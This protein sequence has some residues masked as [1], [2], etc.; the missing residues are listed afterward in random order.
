MTA[1]DHPTTYAGVATLRPM[2]MDVASRVANGLKA[3]LR[4]MFNRRRLFSLNELSDHQLADIGLERA[5]L[6]EAKLTSISVDPTATL[7][8]LSHKRAE[9]RRVRRA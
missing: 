3:I 5:D 9:A 7:S 2:R 4:A 6:F 8:A 1:L